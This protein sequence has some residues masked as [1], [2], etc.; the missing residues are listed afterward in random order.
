M[1]LNLDLLRG[2]FLAL[3]LQAVNRERERKRESGEKRLNDFSTIVCSS[4]SYTMKDEVLV[5]EGVLCVEWRSNHV[6]PL[7]LDSVLR[8][9]KKIS[10]NIGLTV[11]CIIKMNK[12]FIRH[13]QYS[14]I[15]E[16]NCKGKNCYEIYVAFF[17]YR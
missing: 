1:S 13:M 15:E 2:Q 3:E 5:C 8:F 14:I 16:L 7:M 6:K 10:W 9:A 11:W 4:L 12:M 17:L